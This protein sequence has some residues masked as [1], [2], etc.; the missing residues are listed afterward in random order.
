MEWQIV[1]LCT[2]VY[3]YRYVFTLLFISCSL[4]F[5]QFQTTPLLSNSIRTSS[6]MPVAHQLTLFS[7]F[8]AEQ[9]NDEDNHDDEEDRYDNG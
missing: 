4:C 2:Y 9:N 6:L 5:M 3:I 1:A 7:A 8:H